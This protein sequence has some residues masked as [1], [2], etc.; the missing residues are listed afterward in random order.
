M[1]NVHALYLKL[2]ILGFLYF[3]KSFNFKKDFEVLQTHTL[4]ILENLTFNLEKKTE[5]NKFGLLILWPKMKYVIL[6]IKYMDYRK[7]KNSS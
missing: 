3:H 4:Y 1:L 6:I 7:K 5:E 2:R